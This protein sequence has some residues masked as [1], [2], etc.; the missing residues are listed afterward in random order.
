MLS[1]VYPVV[2]WMDDLLR[3][4]VRPDAWQ[5]RSITLIAVKIAGHRV[6]ELGP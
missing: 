1:F 6:S 4:G 3:F 2:A 5:W